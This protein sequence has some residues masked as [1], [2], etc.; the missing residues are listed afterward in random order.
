MKFRKLIFWLHLISGIVTG[1]VV[2][3][4]SITGVALTYQKQMTAWADKKMYKI[5]APANAELLPVSTLVESYRRAKPQNIP[6]SLAIASDPVMPASITAAPNLVTFINP[7]TGYVL[8]EGSQGIRKF[9]RVMTDWHRWLALSGDKRGIGKAITG[10]CNFAFLFLAVSGLYLWWP[11]KWT[12]GIFRTIGW[13]RGGLTGKARDFN[14]HHVFGFWC[15]VPLILIIVSA[16]VISYGW[17][18]RLL[19]RMAGS[20]MTYQAGP[21][22]AHRGGPPS[23]PGARGPMP[24]QGSRMERAPLQLAGI[25]TMLEN[26]RKQSDGWKAISFSLPTAKDKTVAFTVEKGFAGQPQ[27]RSTI[28]VDNVTGAILKSDAYKSMDP[29]LRARMWM[30]FVHTGEYYG[31]TGQTI[32]GIASL[33]GVILVWTGFALTYRRFFSSAEKSES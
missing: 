1:I 5:Q 33:A 29:G 16:L 27:Y 15:L 26:I 21:P 28:A 14:W 19:F 22:G 17:A 23:G 4:M 9:F 11:R 7:Y 31:L 6:I 8:G 10:A 30:R 12:Q 2:L 13:F 20:Q 24:G 32:A 25:D 3:I 18:G